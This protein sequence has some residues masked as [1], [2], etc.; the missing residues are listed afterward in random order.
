MPLWYFWLPPL[1]TQS[2]LAKN[3]RVKKK[4]LNQE[5]VLKPY[6]RKSYLKF[7]ELQLWGFRQRLLI[8]NKQ[9]FPLDF[10]VFRNSPKRILYNVCNTPI[11]N[12]EK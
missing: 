1:S 11:E 3:V 2:Y 10:Q 8:K 12:E 7:Q 5:A 4:L 9:I 6:L